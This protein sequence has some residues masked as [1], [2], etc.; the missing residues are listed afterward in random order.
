MSF[1]SNFCWDETELRRLHSPDTTEPWSPICKLNDTLKWQDSS[2]ALSKDRGVGGSPML[3]MILPLISIWPH[4]LELKKTSLQLIPWPKHLPFAMAH[5]L[6][7]MLLS[8]SEQI[9]F[10]PITVS[11]TE[12]LQWDLRA[13]AS[14]GPEARHHGFWPGSSSRR[15]LKSRRKKQWEEHV[16]ESPS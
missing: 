7:S 5:T 16:K 9:H 13:W 15:E 12:F 3:G 2:K 6:Q 4:Q 1:A 14:L 8:I 10:L 11:L